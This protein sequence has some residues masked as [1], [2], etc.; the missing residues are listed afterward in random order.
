MPSRRQPQFTT[1]AMLHQDTVLHDQSHAGA[2]QWR[3]W[4]L[5][6]LRRMRLR[7]HR[8]PLTSGWNR[9]RTHRGRL[10]GGQ[11]NRISTVPESSE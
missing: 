10:H 2:W 7:T 5:P 8:R 6:C 4:P 11:V 3:P 9:R 1:S